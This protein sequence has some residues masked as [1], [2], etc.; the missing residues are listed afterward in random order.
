MSVYQRVNGR[1][2]KTLDQKARCT[3]CKVTYRDWKF[4]GKDEKCFKCHGIEEFEAPGSL[5]ASEAMIKFIA[6]NR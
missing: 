1:G 5:K 4:I 3:E 6:E 2:H